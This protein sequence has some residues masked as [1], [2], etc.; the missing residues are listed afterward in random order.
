M[1]ILIMGGTGAMGAHLVSKLAEGS[2]QVYVTSRRSRA[3]NGNIQYLTGNAKDDGF[4]KPLLESKWDVIVDFMIYKTDEFASRVERLLVATEQYVFISSARVYADSTG[5][6]CE[7]SP[8][9]VDVSDDSTYLATDEYA[10]SKARQED[11]LF[12]SGLSNWTI[13]RPYVTYSEQ[14][15]Q[16]GALEK[17]GWLYRAVKNRPV[18]INQEMLNKTTTLTYGK[19]V[20]NSMAALLGHKGAL[21]EAFHITSSESLTWQAVLKVY[22]RVLQN[23]VGMELKACS[24]ELE[25]IK[26]WHSAQYQIDY[27]RMYNRQFDNTKINQFVSTCDFVK[28][29]D[30]LEC[31]LSEFLKVPKFGYVDWCAE[32]KKDKQV[33]CDT[34]LTEPKGLKNKLKYVIFRYFLK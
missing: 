32:A 28:P 24:R 25:D 19:D 26:R 2:N 20:A 13:I 7:D 21:G 9:L 17:E 16:L 8:R 11:L 30:G 18:V 10:L 12:N 34:S 6:I 33:G 27:D 22:S 3:N 15:L 5:L 1:K 23:D 31:C 29:T 4:M 14:R